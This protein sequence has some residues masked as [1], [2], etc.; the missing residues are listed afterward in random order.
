ML[1]LLARVI[2]QVVIR[3][4]YESHDTG[5]LQIA[6]AHQRIREEIVARD[7]ETA[8][9][10]ALRHLMACGDSMAQET[11]GGTVPLAGGN[12][13]LTRALARTPPAAKRQLKA[14]GPREST[15]SRRRG[16]VVDRASQYYC[17]V[18]E[19]QSLK[20]PPERQARWPLCKADEAG[21][22]CRRR[23]LCGN[24]SNGRP[25]ISNRSCG[26]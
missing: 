6:R 1:A 3:M 4:D 26:G 11:K 2:R 20:W 18:V 16:S 15:R 5:A 19:R 14:S 9:R 24:F 12:S 22:D 25:Y 8:K 10:R 21:G 17:D 23:A 7:V 13:R